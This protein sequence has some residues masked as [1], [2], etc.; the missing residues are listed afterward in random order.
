M[1]I[2]SSVIE[3]SADNPFYLRNDKYRLLVLTHTDEMINNHQIC[4]IYSVI[5]EIHYHLAVSVILVNNQNLKYG[6]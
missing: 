5:D 3:H 4:F 1:L 6:Y 2:L